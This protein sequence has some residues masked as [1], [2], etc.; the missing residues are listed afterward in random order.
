VAHSKQIAAHT[1]HTSHEQ[2][3]KLLVDYPFLL[4]QADYSSVAPRIMRAQ[5]PKAEKWKL[6]PFFPS[7]PKPLA[8]PAEYQNRSCQVL[9]DNNNQAGRKKKKTAAIAVDDH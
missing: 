4:L 6:V 3:V 7:E 8:I 1:T 5:K 2:K 9:L